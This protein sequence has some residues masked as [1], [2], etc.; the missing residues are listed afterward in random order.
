[1]HAQ[2]AREGVGRRSRQVARPSAR[3]LSV[4][5]PALMLVAR[6]TTDMCGNRTVDTR[7]SLMWAGGFLPIRTAEAVP[8][9]YVPT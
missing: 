7:Y 3:G 5:G 4:S 8:A 6:K 2:T 1:M 9:L